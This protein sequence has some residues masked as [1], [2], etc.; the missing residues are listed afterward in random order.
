MS[1]SERKTSPN[2]EKAKEV[3][4]KF[5]RGVPATEKPDFTSDVQQ[6]VE[7]FAD[8]LAETGEGFLSIMHSFNGTYWILE[9]LSERRTLAAYHAMNKWNDGN[10]GAFMKALNVEF[11]D[12]FWINVVAFKSTGSMYSAYAFKSKIPA[13]DNQPAN[14][15]GSTK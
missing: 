9:N 6:A 2:V 4:R 7:A 3:V 10:K 12:K 5:F 15:T 8:Y 13:G 11:N 1:D 14:T